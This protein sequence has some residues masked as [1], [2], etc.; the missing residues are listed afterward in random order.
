MIEFYY[1]DNSEKW[2]GKQIFGI[3]AKDITEADKAFEGW[4][5]K[6]PAKMPHISCQINKK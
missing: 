4:H 5:G 2:H 1:W 6:H 3:S